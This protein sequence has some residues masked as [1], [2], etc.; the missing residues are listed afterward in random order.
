MIFLVSQQG[1]C[2]DEERK[3]NRGNTIGIRWFCELFT[4][5]PRCCKH[6]FCT[7]LLLCAVVWICA[8]N[9]YRSYAVLTFWAFWYFATIKT[10]VVSFVRVKQVNMVLEEV[11]EL[12]VSIFLQLL[13]TI[14]G[15]SIELCFFVNQSLASFVSMLC[16]RVFSL[17]SE[18]WTCAFVTFAQ[19]CC[20]NT[21]SLFSVVQWS[22]GWRPKNNEAGPD[23]AQWK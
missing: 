2:S 20:T 13:Y 7:N 16:T 12:W 17:Y 14:L 1:A 9:G 23:I 3:G 22:Y 4:G 18:C 15:L 5:I 19:Y 11:T 6:Y 8:L 10:E 21:V